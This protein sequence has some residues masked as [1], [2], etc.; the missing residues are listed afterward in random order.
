MIS[1]LGALV[2]LFIIIA[3]AVLSA[4]WFEP[5]S[6]FDGSSFHTFIAVLGGLGIFVT[7]LFYYNVVELQQ[8][9][10]QLMAVQELSRINDTL[11]DNL[12]NKMKEASSVIPN[13]VASLTPLSS[14]GCCSGVTG[15]PPEN[16]PDPIDT[17]A[18]TLKSNLSYAVFN[19]WQDVIGSNEF[20]SENIAGYVASFLQYANSPQLYTEWN[21]M[22]LNFSLKAQTFGNLLF[23]FALPITEQTVA[24]YQKVAQELINTETFQSLIK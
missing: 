5:Y 22:W 7:F 11:I 20:T 6:H 14:L 19:I 23:Q 13:F 9:Q 2:L 8:Q 24:N 1:P 12:L 17:R 3:V 15:C 10:Q 4:I 21:Y 16:P 18:C